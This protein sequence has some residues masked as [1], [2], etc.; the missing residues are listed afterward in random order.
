MSD[1]LGKIKSGAGR[2]AFEADKLVDVKR[3]EIEIGNLKRQKEALHTKLGEMTYRSY[4]N[5]EP[6]SREVAEV[7]QSISKLEQQIGEK[8]EEIKRI[9]AG[10]FSSKG[11][12][13]PTPVPSTTIT[14][15]EPP[16]VASQ[17][18]SA[19]PSRQINYCTNCGKE[20]AVTNKFCPYCG[21]KMA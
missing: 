10:T 11:G 7:C 2:V 13:S 17:T 16:P 18:T 12:P 20:V 14:Q 5:K 15:V 3:I 21:T 19:T 4:I 6:E 1:F 8:E 9:N